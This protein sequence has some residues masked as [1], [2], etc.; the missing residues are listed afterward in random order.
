MALISLVVNLVAQGFYIF[1]GIAGIGFLIGFHEFGHFIFCKLFKIA[2][3]TFSIGM[4]PKIFS[5][6]IGQTN[7]TLSALPLGGYV[8]IQGQGENQ[9]E[10]GNT[11]SFTQ[12]PY[13]QKMLVIA[14]GIVFNV[15]FAYVAIS[16]LYFFGMPKLPPLY[17]GNAS[18]QVSMV[19]AGSPAQQA[20]LQ[21]SDAILKID[22]LSV[23]N[24]T[25]ELLNTIRK[26]PGQQV[27]LTILHDDQ[28]Q[29]LPVTIGERTLPNGE[30]EGYL[31][32]DFI[33]PQ[34]GLAESIKLGVQGTHEIIWQTILVF[35]NMFV[36]KDTKNL[37]GPIMV[38]SQTIKSA[39]KGF[40]I[41]LLL[42]A[43]ISINLAVLNIIPVPIMDGGQA[44]FYTIEALIRR[45]LPEQV[46]LY[47]HYACWI[48][49]MGLA[50]FLTVKDIF[51]LFC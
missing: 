27:I 19:E 7:F 6:K 44:L 50:L 37:G 40:K 51:R 5:K 31:G 16:S 13:Y 45:P 34:Y 26:K 2:T 43:Y 10:A 12:K 42:L 25:L 46:K 18:T 36:K 3:P 49:V 39:S 14:G 15:L 32:L 38:I 21:S 29:T 35:K 28:E 41:F 47:I 48:A 30:K 11:Y 9:D 17:P 22:G 1:L 33:I 24:N 8:E 23:S 4:G 20:G